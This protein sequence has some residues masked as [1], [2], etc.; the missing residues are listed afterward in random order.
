MKILCLATEFPPAHGYGLARYISEH[1]NALAQTGAQVHVACNNWDGENGTYQDDGVQ[2]N[3]APFFIPF[4]GYTWVADALQRNVQLLG[5]GIEMTRRNGGYDILHAHDWLAAGAAKALKATYG[6][7]LVVS[8]HD[9]EIGKNSGQLD[10]TQH[11]I[12]QMERWMCD[13]AERVLVNSRFI[14]RELVEAY[15]V[16]ADKLDVVGCGVNP[17]AFETDAEVAP[18]KS[19]FCGPGE[20]LVAFVGRL[21]GVKGPH[22][23]LEAMPTVLSVCPGT[24]FVFAGDGAMQQGLE[25]RAQ[26]LKLDDRVRFLGHIRGKVLATFYHAADIV[27]VPSLYEPLGMVALEAMVCGRPVIASDTGGLREVVVPG[28][29]GVTVP[30]NDSRELASA[31]VRLLLNPQAAQMLGAQGRQRALTDFR[32]DAVAQRTQASYALALGA[33]GGRA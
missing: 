26:E 6:M 32:W 18:F 25:H 14:A 4:E 12:S 29:T 9:T 10:E 8:M 15:G 28:A 11:Y 22:V 7:P 5:R 16:P 2:V 27:V 3:N 13:Q 17:Q 1:C 19:L 21:A 20:R 31:I 33:L 23:L 24:R 30:P